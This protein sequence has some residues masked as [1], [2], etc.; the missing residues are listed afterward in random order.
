MW[1][2][3]ARL[4]GQGASRGLEGPTALRGAGN[5]A[6]RMRS[7]DGVVTAG[8]KGEGSGENQGKYLKGIKELSFK[9]VTG[10]A[11]QL[12]C[13]Y[14]NAHSLANKQQELEATVL[15]ENYGIVVVT[16]T[17]WD[18]SHDWSVAIDSYKL[19]RRDRRER[20]CCYLYQERN[21]M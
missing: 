15:L 4:E 16:E 8:A 10:P 1:D 18:D 13:F 2:D 3:I 17:W 14:T 6:A 11:A 19:F 21:R 12:K 9:E 7:Y 5:T 20:G